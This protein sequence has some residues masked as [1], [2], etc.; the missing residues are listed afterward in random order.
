MRTGSESSILDVPFLLHFAKPLNAEA[1]SESI[2]QH[3]LALATYSPE[4]QT[5]DF[6]MGGKGSARTYSST[7]SGIFGGR[8]DD[9]V[10]DS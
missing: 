10:S 8:D 3:T 2:D 6:T 9:K 5:S 1:Y 7:Y 4:T